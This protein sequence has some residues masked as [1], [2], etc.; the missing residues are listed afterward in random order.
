MTVDD[1]GNVYVATKAGIEVFSPE[2]TLWETLEL[3][4]QPTNCTLGDQTL[5]ITA[6]QSVYAIPLAQP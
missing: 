1:Q 3:P 5:F 6:R 4:S 2:G